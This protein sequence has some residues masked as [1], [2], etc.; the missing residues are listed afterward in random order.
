[1]SA[2]INRSPAAGG[3]LE[4][5][6][7]PIP[8][9]ALGILLVTPFWAGVAFI[10]GGWLSVGI[11]LIFAGLIEILL[12]EIRPP[13]YRVIKEDRI[14]ATDRRGRLRLSRAEQRRRAAA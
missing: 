12:A 3:R 13:T 9:I 4:V 5:S 6:R 7:L 1:M 2:P 10:F 8:P 11:V 14:G